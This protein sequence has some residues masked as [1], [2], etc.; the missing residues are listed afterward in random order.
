MIVETLVQDSGLYVCH[1]TS[2]V[3]D[4]SVLSGPLELEVL[5][6]LYIYTVYLQLHP[7]HYFIG[8]RNWLLRSDILPGMLTR[9]QTPR[10]RPR[11]NIPAFC[12]Q[13]GAS[14]CDRGSIFCNCM[15]CAGRKI[16]K[17]DVYAVRKYKKLK[18]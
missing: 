17:L 10:P 5:G 15:S 18:S 4:K 1:V 12:S 7:E 13:N 14:F 9:P 11:P 2:E 6:E 8:L 16:C 3:L